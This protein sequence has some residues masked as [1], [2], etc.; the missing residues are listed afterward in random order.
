MLV[1]N[2]STYISVRASIAKILVVVFAKEKASNNAFA[3]H[4]THR[5][6]FGLPTLKKS[7]IA[8]ENVFWLHACQRQGS[9]GREDRV[10]VGKQARTERRTYSVT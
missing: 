8:T 5:L 2:R 7:T 1:F 3:G 4:V 6:S 9:T 10:I